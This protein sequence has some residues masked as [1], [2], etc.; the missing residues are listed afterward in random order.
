MNIILIIAALAMLPINKGEQ[1]VTPQHIV[2]VQA[3]STEASGT[4]KLQSIG[5]YTTAAF[6]TWNETNVVGAVTNVTV[7][8]G[9]KTTVHPVTND[10]LDVTMTSGRYSAVTNLYVP[11][12]LLFA[13]G[14]AFTNSV[15]NVFTEN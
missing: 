3:S 11:G 13:S 1:V 15:I 14:S 10:V 8:N 6:E 12:G 5:S 2:A 4:L 7:K 9:W